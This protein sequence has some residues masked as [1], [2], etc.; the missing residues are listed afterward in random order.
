MVKNKDV[1]ELSI[2]EMLLQTSNTGINQT[3][4]CFDKNDKAT[5]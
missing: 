2:N 3:S 4:R 1:T 5:K